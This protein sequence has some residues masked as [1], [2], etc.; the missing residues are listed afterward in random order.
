MEVWKAIA[1]YEGIYELSKKSEL[2]SLKFGTE[3]ILK[4]TLDGKY[5]KVNLCL[6][7]NQKRIRVHQL[8]AETFLG[9]IPC[10][11]ELVVD[12]IDTNPLNN[13]LDNLR[14]VPQ[15]INSNQ[16]HLKSTSKYTGVS[17]I[18]NSKKWQCLIQLDGKD[19]YLGSFDNELEASE[20]YENA[21]KNHLAGLPIEVKKPNFTSKYKGV[22]WNK[23]RNKWIVRICINGKNKHLGLFTNEIDAHNAYQ[24]AYKLLNLKQ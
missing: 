20:Y 11:M 7:G 21:L 15:R 23:P 3:R 8:M 9:H 12:H 17:L 10:G 2:K 5:Y 14:I 19:K 13:N 1:G 22:S 6:K 4:Q 18:K 24:S 16:K